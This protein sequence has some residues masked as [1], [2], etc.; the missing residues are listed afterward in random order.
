MLKPYKEVQ[1]WYPALEPDHGAPAQVP[2]ESDAVDDEADPGAPRYP[3]YIR[4]TEPEPFE[5]P[6]ADEPATRRSEFIGGWADWVGTHAP[7]PDD[8]YPDS[9]GAVVP[10]SRDDEPG[11]GRTRGRR[12]ARSS[13]NRPSD[14][15]AEES[16]GPGEQR[17][18]ARFGSTAEI[19]RDEDGFEASG[20]ARARRGEIRTVDRGGRRGRPDSGP[21]PAAREFDLDEEVEWRAHGPASPPLRAYTR[22]GRTRVAVVATIAVLLLG[23]AGACALYLLQGK[24]D[25]A[26]A[27]PGDVGGAAVAAS[28]TVGDGESPMMRLTAAGGDSSRE[29]VATAGGH[30]PTERF[31]HVLRG[32]EVGGTGSGPDAIMRFQHA[33]Y[34]ERSAARA[35]EVVAPGAAV[36]PE[37]VIARGIAS[38]PQGTEYCVR[39]VTMAPDRYS[40]EVTERRP[41]AGPATYGR[42]LVTTAVVGGRTL[43][44]GITAG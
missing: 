7:G 42:Q 19:D 44:T 31:D 41:G 2:G 24:D 18:P 29:R 12:R 17:G 33:Y 10:F 6:F 26:G 30:C 36:S 37:S 14:D 13:A 34:V 1:R 32:A 38:V 3:H 39:V 21:I 9:E 43:I 27:A 28:T 22:P 35:L 4:D 11:D 20:R 23:V 16:H 15:D 40:V 25:R 8:D 5:I